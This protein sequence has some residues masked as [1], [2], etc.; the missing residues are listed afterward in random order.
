MK[1]KEKKTKK[2][3][4]P[5]SILNTFQKCPLSENFYV[6]GD[7]KWNPSQLIEYCKEQGYRTFDLPLA[8]IDLTSL[9]WDNIT[10]LDTFIWQM[11]RVLQCDTNHPIIL[12]DYGQIADGYHRV[13]KAILDGKTTIKAIRMENMPPSPSK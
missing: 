9:P 3:N 8:A 10:S 4:T 5:P 7:E 1:N 11:H 2:Q 12:D 13:C 6:R